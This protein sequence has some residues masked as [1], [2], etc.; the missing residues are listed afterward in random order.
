MSRQPLV[1]LRMLGRATIAVVGVA[2]AFL[3]APVAVAQ[4]EAEADGAITAA[5]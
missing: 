3:L 1:R 5:W 2:T 4:P